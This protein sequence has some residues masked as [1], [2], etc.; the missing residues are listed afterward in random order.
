MTFCRFCSKQIYWTDSIRFETR[1]SQVFHHINH[2]PA[3]RD[4]TDLHLLLQYKMPWTMTRSRGCSTCQ[5]SRDWEFINECFLA[6]TYLVL[7][8]EKLKHYSR[9]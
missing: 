6:L 4:N 5:E 1:C 8:V 2:L 9:H 3:G 7:F